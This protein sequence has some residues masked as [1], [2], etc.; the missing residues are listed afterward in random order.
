MLLMISDR[1]TRIL[2]SGEMRARCV[3]ASLVHICCAITLLRV[4]GVVLM[5]L[6]LLM[7]ILMPVLLLVL[8]L[9]G[10]LAIGRACV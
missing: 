2:A 1:I 8:L 9:A 10:S 4:V 7:M 5:L 3:T 6:L